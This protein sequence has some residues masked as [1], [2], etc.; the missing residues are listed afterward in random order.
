M[1][2]SLFCGDKMNDGERAQ[3]IIM[4][5]PIDRVPYV[6]SA[7]GFM[8]LNIGKTINEWYQ[9]P[10]VAFDSGRMSSEQYGAMWLPFGGYPA[11]GPWELGG[12]IKWPT[13]EFDQCP[14]AEPAISNEEEAWNL[15]I[16]PDNELK[17][18]GYLPYIRLFAR[19]AQ[20]IGSP[21]IIPIYGPFTTAGNIVGLE[22]LCRWILK[23][24]DLAHRVIR[25]ATD[26]LIAV[27]RIIIDE[28][29]AQGYTPGLSTASM[30]NNIISPKNAQEFGLPYLIEYV[31]ALTDFGIMG[32]GFHPC[33]E[34]NLNYELYPDVPL[35][36]LSI[37]SISHEVDLEKAS[38][39]FKDFIISGNINPTTLQMGTPE[40]VYEECRV[41]IEKGKKHGRGFILTSGCEM[42]P[43]TPPY[44][45]YMMAKAVNDFGYY[46]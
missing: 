22:R 21:F 39:T 8:A 4:G 31:K 7:S 11:L 23:K 14:N 41:A 37:I 30:A 36:P 12:E 43:R 18:T 1:G 25:L 44:N 16:P 26:F 46:S 32:M 5:K 38:V 15:K 9:D 19:I 42:A 34:Q 13:G 17:E 27:N 6:I 29:G 28:F 20:S 10:Q 45:V 24:K 33:G 35:P 3:A 2:T 40:E